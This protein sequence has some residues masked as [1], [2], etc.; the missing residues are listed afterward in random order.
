[1]VLESDDADAGEAGSVMV[2]LPDLPAFPL[3]VLERNPTTDWS[4]SF[5][6]EEDG[7]SV[8]AALAYSLETLLLRTS[9]LLPLLR[10]NLR[11][12]PPLPLVLLVLLR[13]LLALLAVDH[14]SS[15]S[16]T[17]GSRFRCNMGI[18]GCSVS[19]VF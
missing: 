16:S 8:P 2:K 19:G 6:L 17:I 5:P 1:L 12:L 18:V 4:I 10:I 13:R 14:R 7:A 11:L 3:L 15:E 9:F